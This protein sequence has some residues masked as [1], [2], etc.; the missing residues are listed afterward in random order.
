MLVHVPLAVHLRLPKDE[1]QSPIEVAAEMMGD[2]T[3]G[4]APDLAV[5]QVVDLLAVGDFIGIPVDEE[6][7]L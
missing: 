7:V 5:L 2:E 1:L 4:R 3:D 6:S